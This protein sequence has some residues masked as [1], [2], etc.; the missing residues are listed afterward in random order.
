ME[1]LPSHVLATDII[2]AM[3]QLRAELDDWTSNGKKVAAKR[4]RKLTLSLTKT[5][6]DF[7]S[8]SVKDAE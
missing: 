5:M 2:E 1:Q 3:T 4:A 7:R 8:A 6:K